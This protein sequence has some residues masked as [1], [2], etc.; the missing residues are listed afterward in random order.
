MNKATKMMLQGVLLAAFLFLGI[1]SVSAFSFSPMSV[2]IAPSGTQAIVTFK[3]SNE[4]DKPIAV[5]IS[6][7]S[8]VVAPDGSEKNEDIGNMF[9]VFPLKFVLQPNSS[10]DIKVQ[11]KGSAAIGKE[12]AFRVIADQLPVDF[13][14]ATTSGVNILLRYVAALY[15]AP[16]NAT[17][18]LVVSEIVGAEKDGKRGLSVSVRN[19]GTR[20]ALI[21][22]PAI[23]IKSKSDSTPIAFSGDSLK[24]IDGQNILA[25]STRTFFVPWESAQ[26]GVTYEGTFSAD[27]E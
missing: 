16:K 23:Q 11:Y 24:E 9:T 22:N 1:V 2:T 7:K 3:A 4:T 27:F 20:H 26:I 5:A 13:T 17:P 25:A 18:K 19:D 21:S 6:V 12:L 14:P 8:R 10:Q 15:V